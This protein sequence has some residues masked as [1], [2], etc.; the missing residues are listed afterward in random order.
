MAI[1]ILG[2][3][4]I[5][6]DP[7]KAKE[8]LKKAKFEKVDLKNPTK[9]ENIIP[10]IVAEGLISV[11]EDDKKLK[12]HKVHL[13]SPL[14]DADENILA[15]DESIQKF[16]K[17][18]GTLAI[19]SHSLVAIEKDDYDYSCQLTMYLL[20]H[21]KKYND[22]NI[23][24]VSDDPE[25]DF[26]RRY[27]KDRHEFLVSRVPN[28][29]ILF[30]DGPFIGGQHSQQNKE[31]VR[32][33]MKKDVLPVFYIKNSSG[34][35]LI[36]NLEGDLK[37]NFNSDLH[38]A[39]ELLEI[40]ERTSYVLYEDKYNKENSKVFGYIKCYKGLPQRFEFDV[41][42]YQSY[43]KNIDSVL[44]L[45]YYYSALNGDITNPQIRP[46]AIAERFARESLNYMSPADLITTFNLDDT[47]NAMRSFG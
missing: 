33:L 29:S 45:I 17:L 3:R 21:A 7:K 47:M 4:I 16:N 38:Y 13:S 8:A 10:D 14:T 42:T 15:Y 44:N 40:G 32:E 20:S 25:V 39:N 34:R 36:D 46:I 30:V 18:Q 31:L 11:L 27:L 6:F 37:T 26:K 28:H 35:M 24:I 9:E 2:K 5:Y 23:A 43:K 1:S 22:I 41:K 19:T 12:R